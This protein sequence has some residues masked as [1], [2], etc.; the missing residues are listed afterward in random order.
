M[1]VVVIAVILSIHII[2][3]NGPLAEMETARLISGR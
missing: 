2:F 3:F 1:L